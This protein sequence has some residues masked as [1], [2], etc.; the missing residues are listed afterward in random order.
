MPQNYR[1]SYI[2]DDLFFAYYRPLLSSKY[3]NLKINDNT[4]IDDLNFGGIFF[5]N[6]IKNY[7]NE[8]SSLIDIL[9]KPN[10]NYYHKTRLHYPF[11]FFYITSAHI[12]KDNENISKLFPFLIINKTFAD[13]YS[14]L[15]VNLKEKINLTNPTNLDDNLNSIFN[16]NVFFNYLVN[17]YSLPAFFTT[18]N[19]KGLF[20]SNTSVFSSLAPSNNN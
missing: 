18:D 12:N 16:N 6:R 7:I 15:F 3:N 8:R 4:S 20:F 9:S 14:K 11:L 1:E 5:F 10:Y 17:L 2:Y 13:I 19:H